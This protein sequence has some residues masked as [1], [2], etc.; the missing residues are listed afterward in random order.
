MRKWSK[1][2]NYKTKVTEES[3][4]GSSFIV[5]DEINNVTFDRNILLLSYFQFVKVKFPTVQASCNVLDF[6]HFDVWQMAAREIV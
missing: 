6:C 4:Q 5:I 3:H 2:H 1:W